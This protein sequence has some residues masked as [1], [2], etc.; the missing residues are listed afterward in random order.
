[1]DNQKIKS[2]IPDNGKRFFI[3]GRVQTGSG[4]H[5]AS[6]AMGNGEIFLGRKGEEHL[7]CEAGHS[8]VS[9]A[10]NE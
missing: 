1:V 10:R 5:P 4:G 9:D 6:Y 2:S 7:G 3:F 8:P